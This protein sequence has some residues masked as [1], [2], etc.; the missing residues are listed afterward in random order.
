[1]YSLGLMA[2]KTSILFQYLRFF[3]HQTF[4][5]LAWALMAFVL[6]GGSA[7]LLTSSLSCLPVAFNWD[8]TI[9]GGY[10]I[11][12]PPVWYTMAG[13]T[14]VTDIAVLVLPMPVLKSLHLPKR[15]KYSLMATFGLAGLYVYSLPI[16]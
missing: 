16:G 8:K 9:P 6:V 15:Q 2:L 3:V 5:Q 7:L 11:N 10:C 1:M 12:Q 4:R 13:F 14:I